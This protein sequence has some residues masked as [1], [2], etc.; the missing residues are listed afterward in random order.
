M[1]FTI[2]TVL[3]RISR[4]ERH[5]PVVLVVVGKYCPWGF[6][7]LSASINHALTGIL[8]EC[9]IVSYSAYVPLGWVAVSPKITP[10][11]W[12]LPLTWRLITRV[13]L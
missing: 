6:R 13:R 3:I 5:K 7:F 12:S 2:L 1:S 8:Q 4:L 9:G 11:P 10:G